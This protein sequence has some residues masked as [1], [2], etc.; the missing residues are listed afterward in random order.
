MA[1]IENTLAGVASGDAECTEPRV[2]SLA[3]V[4]GLAGYSDSEDTGVLRIPQAAQSIGYAG[5]AGG[6]KEHGHERVPDLAGNPGLDNAQL[7]RQVNG[8]RPKPRSSAFG[9]WI[10]DCVQVDSLAKCRKVSFRFKRTPK[11]RGVMKPIRGFS[12]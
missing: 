4:T 9:N 1:G 6:T 2:T 5:L 10:L 8:A 3:G 11:V 12:Q 7:Q